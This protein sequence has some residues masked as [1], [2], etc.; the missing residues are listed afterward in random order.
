VPDQRLAD[1][2][3]SPFDSSFEISAR[4]SSKPLC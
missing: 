4:D 1:G 2:V 3:D